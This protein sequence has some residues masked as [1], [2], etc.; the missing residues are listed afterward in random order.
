MR[1]VSKIAEYF[2]VIFKD[3]SIIRNEFRHAEQLNLA[4]L[5]EHMTSLIFSHVNI[6]NLSSHVKISCFHSKRNSCN[7]LHAIKFPWA[8]FLVDRVYGANKFFL[9]I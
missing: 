7:S 6:S 9:T 1:R 2:R 8:S 5:I 3:V 4:N